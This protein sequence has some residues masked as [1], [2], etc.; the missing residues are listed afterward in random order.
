M[1]DIN[2]IRKDF[3]FLSQSINDKH[4]VF[5]DTGASAQK[6]QVVIDAIA[7]AYA[8]SYANV[9]RGVYFLSQE[10]S[11]NYENVRSIVQKFIHAKSRNEIVITKGTTEA[12]NLVANSLDDFINVGYSIPLVTWFILA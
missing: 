12:I 5:F 1:Y 8:F 10:A 11:E 2:K 9:H 7:D 6:P 3:P 4:V